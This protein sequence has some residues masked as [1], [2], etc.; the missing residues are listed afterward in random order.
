MSRSLAAALDGMPVEAVDGCLLCAN[1]G[2]AA[3]PRWDRLL[4]LVPPY[5]TRRCCRCGLR[6]LSPRPGAEARLV[7]YGNDHYF[8]SGVVADYSQFAEERSS[9]FRLRAEALAR[10]GVR[11]LLD[12]GAATGEFVAAAKR[13]GIDATGVEVSADARREA[14]AKHDVH[15]LSPEAMEQ[16]N[17]KFDAVH[18]NHVLEH[19]PDPLSHLRW[20]H[21][22]LREGGLLVSE[23]PYQF[24]NL[25]DRLRRLRGSGGRQQEFNAFSVHHTYF[26]T[27]ANYRKIVEAAGFR[28]EFLVTPL[29]DN[30]YIR[31]GARRFL[32]WTLRAAATCFRTGDAIEIHARKPRRG[33]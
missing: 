15:L 25:T 12:Y 20:C 28:V 17:R 23:V 8:H 14:V 21:H 32:E 2:V 1:A 19:M 22:R 33:I 13:A 26:F 11:T 24:D 29:S 6:W 31:S 16:V 9:H 10:A 18:M 3:D 27:P 5:V 4:A 7:I 30:P